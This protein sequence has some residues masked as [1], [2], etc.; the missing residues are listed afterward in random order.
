[1]LMFPPTARTLCG[2]NNST[3]DRKLA[4]TKSESY[5]GGWQIRL[6]FCCRGI[7]NDVDQNVIHYKN[8]P[9]SKPRNNAGG[10][11]MAGPDGLTMGISEYTWSFGVRICRNILVNEE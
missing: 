8:I 7:L 11:P 5:I 6:I 3:E 4:H 9:L 1:V 10:G 2:Q